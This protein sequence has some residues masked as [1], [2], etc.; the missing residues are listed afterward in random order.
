MILKGMNC[1]WNIIIPMM[2]SPLVINFSPSDND[3]KLFLIDIYYGDLECI[4]ESEDTT[5]L[6][7]P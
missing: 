2:E 5:S 4:A 7:M 3:I 1:I 6:L